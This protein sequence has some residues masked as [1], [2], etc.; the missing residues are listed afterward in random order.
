M[1]TTKTALS[2]YFI[3]QDL[4]KVCLVDGATFD[5]ITSNIKD[6]KERY[7]LSKFDKHLQNLGLTMQDYCEK[8]LN[9]KWPICPKTNQ[10][11]GFAPKGYGLKISTR[12]NSRIED[13]DGT[14]FLHKT[15]KIKN[16][17]APKRQ[18]SDEHRTKIALSRKNHPLKARHSQKHTEETKL[19]MAESTAKGWAAGRFNRRPS[20]EI[21]VEDFLKTLSLTSKFTPQF[22]I[23]YFTV[24]F[25]CPEFKIA[26]EC[27]GT[28]FHIDPRVYP[29]GPICAVQRRNFGRDIAKRKWCVDRM[30]WVIIELWETEINDCQFKEILLCKLR[31]LNLLNESVSVLPLTLP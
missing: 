9:F 19:K 27:Q 13:H 7:Y 23:D 21:K 28:F 17:N 6:S 25:A 15:K 2:T 30:G 31:E 10:R 20:T 11:T 16:P 8:Y 5:S 26:I 18:F 14:M 22:R 4:F 12:R 29:N 24:D 1:T 3:P